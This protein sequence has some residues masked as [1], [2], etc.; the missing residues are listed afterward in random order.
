MTLLSVRNVKIRFRSGDGKIHAVNDVS[1]DMA[2]GQ[3]L[4]L[5]GES[6]SGKSQIAMAIMGLLARNAEVEGEILYNGRNLIGLPTAEL[7]RLRAKEIALIFQDPMSS[8]NPYMTIER[9]LGEVVELHEGASRS[10]ARKRALEVMDAV[11]IP[12]AK[13][14]LKAYPHEFSG[15]MRQRI[16]IA[17][18]L[19]CKP[20]LILADEPTTA[21]DVTVQAQIMALLDD[22]QRDMGTAV[23]LIT[24]DL[25]V[26]A[27]FCEDTMVLYGGRMM[28]AAPTLSI[29]DAPGHP[30]TRGL[31]RAV[32]RITDDDAELSAIPGSPPNQ[33]GAPTACPF[34]PRCV[35]AIPECH[36]TLPT[37]QDGRACIRPVE[38]LT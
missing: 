8:L 13:N 7:N 34:A 26:V 33:T 28:E 2:Q 31:L 21:L 12:D 22:I 37:M 29:F 17:M 25:G 14:R 19:I 4:A 36:R 11:K 35:D 5:V 16:V 27:G 23:L 10:D 15:G 24:H 9:Q 32:P 1:F 20:R 18:A 38:E 6:G 30:Y 3:K